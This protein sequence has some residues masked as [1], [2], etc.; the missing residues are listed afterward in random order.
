MQPQPTLKRPKGE[1]IGKKKGGEESL[2]KEQRPPG[3]TARERNL[4][5]KTMGWYTREKSTEK[6]ERDSP[7]PLKK[8][9]VSERG[10]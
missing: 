4:S 9:K 2:P 10:H 8:K 7:V 1:H 5:N 6:K 3:S